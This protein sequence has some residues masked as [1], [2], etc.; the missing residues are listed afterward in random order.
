M[1]EA[2]V[3]AVWQIGHHYVVRNV[4]H[5]LPELAGHT[6]FLVLAPIIGAE[7]AVESILASGRGLACDAV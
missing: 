4:A 5:R 1:V 6:T 2:I 7:A 3:G